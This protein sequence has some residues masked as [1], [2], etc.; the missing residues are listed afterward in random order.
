MVAGDRFAHWAGEAGWCKGKVLEKSDNPVGYKV[1][2]DVNL[3]AGQAD[4]QIIGTFLI[5]RA[6]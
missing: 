2:L 5:Q 6:P 3:E 4:G 1:L